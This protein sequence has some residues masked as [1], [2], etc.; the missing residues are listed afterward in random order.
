M[1]SPSTLR[2]RGV[3]NAG[4]LHNRLRS[5]FGVVAQA[6]GRWRRRQQFWFL[7]GSLL[8]VVVIAVSL[9]GTLGTFSTVATGSISGTVVTVGLGVSTFPPGH[10]ILEVERN[11][12]V[13]GE[14]RLGSRG[15]F[16]FAGPAGTYSVVLQGWFCT[17]RKVV[18]RKGESRHIWVHCAL[19]VAAP[20]LKATAP[21]PVVTDQSAHALK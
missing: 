12:T 5:A 16:G 18:V 15:G 9:L 17:N 7:A 20:A 6:K 11:G 4:R 2:L 8:G 14:L 13:V 19:P 10:S 3:T 1:E 21:G